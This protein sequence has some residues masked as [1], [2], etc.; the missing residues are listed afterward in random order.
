MAL[1][2]RAVVAASWL[3]LVA[4]ALFQGCGD[5][6]EGLG[7]GDA[8]PSSQD[9][10]NEPAVAID[11]GDATPSP[12]AADAK[13]A[14]AA[15]AGVADA[16]DAT[17]P[18]GADAADVVV[19]D[20]LADT[21]PDV[22]PDAPTD[23]SVDGNADAALPDASIADAG[24]AAADAGT[25]F[26]VRVSVNA[27]DQPS[28]GNAEEP[29][30]SDDGRFVAFSSTA[31]NLVPN[32]TNAARDIFLRDVVHATTVRVSVTSNGAQADYDSDA[33]VI[34]AD[35]RYV[36]FESQAINL[37]PGKSGFHSDV[38]RHDMQTGITLCVSLDPNGASG[39]GESN[40]PSISDDG[41]YI[42]FESTS[43]T[44]VAGLYASARQVYVRDVQTGVTS[45]V[46][47]DNAGI[48]ADF[49]SHTAAISGNGRVVAFVSGATNLVPGDTNGVEDVF[50]RDLVAGTTE[51]VS[52][53]STSV[54]SDGHTDMPFISRDGSIVLFSGTSTT[55]A[56][57]TVGAQWDRFVHDR[58]AGTTALVGPRVNGSNSIGGTSLGRAAASADGR[59]V[60]F[61]ASDPNVLPGKNSSGYDVYVFDRSNGVVSRVN[62]TPNG[63][64]SD[65]SSLIPALSG[66]GRFVVYESNATNLAATSGGASMQLYETTRP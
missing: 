5:D 2:P 23:A 36:A 60:G 1:P 45:L 16:A 66:N 55:I 51:R 28:A 37:A 63:V 40:F 30:V 33:P 53:S 27:A 32:D 8:G 65:G 3:A 25:V 47:A 18:D 59:Y 19:V 26:V 38:I 54:Q 50:V 4:V 49:N 13:A 48:Q 12:D 20:A 64:G 6:G 31:R 21:A 10:T 24:D 7:T 17:S 56:P 43:H 44:L 11:A 57:V 34:S 41:R 22:S 35:G 46:S 61:Y 52:V 39:T 62:R 15:D 9:A 58:T 29:A 42:A 14:D